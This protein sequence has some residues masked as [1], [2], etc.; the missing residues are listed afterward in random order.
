VRAQSGAHVAQAA[1][2]GHEA[3]ATHHA[4]GRRYQLATGLLFRA[5]GSSKLKVWCR[6]WFSLSGL[7]FRTH[8][9]KKS[10]LALAT[11]VTQRASERPR[12]SSIVFAGLGELVGASPPNGKSFFDQGK[13]IWIT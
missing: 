6:V 7:P 5:L 10:W 12:P 11:A 3:T 2:R 13:N 1:E 8:K 4:R 9:I